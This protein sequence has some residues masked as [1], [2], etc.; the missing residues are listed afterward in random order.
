MHI[1]F[2]TKLGCSL[3]DDAERMM[4]LVRED[5]PLSWTSV[6]IL[7]DDVAHEKYMFMIPVIEMNNEVLL[8][9]NIGYVDIVEL[10]VK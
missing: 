3:C 10:F 9:G 2:Y 5:Y 1:V 6:N 8:S 4:E 7:E